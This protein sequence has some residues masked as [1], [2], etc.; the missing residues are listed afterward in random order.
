MKTIRLFKMISGEFCIAEIVSETQFVYRTKNPVTI[1]MTRDPQGNPR[2]AFQDW[3][4][5]AEEQSELIV[6]KAH[7]IS[8]MKP[9]AEMIANYQ[10]RFS[11]IVTPPAGIIL[12]PQ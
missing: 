4:P 9:V 10:Q 11:S 6:Q 3:C 2:L 5:F 1:V 7:V 8:D 12:P